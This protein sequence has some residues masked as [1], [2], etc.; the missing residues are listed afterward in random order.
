[1]ALRFLSDLAG[2]MLSYFKISTLRLKNDSN[3]LRVRNAGDSSD[4]PLIA[5]LLSATGEDIELNQDAA[6]SG[7]DWKMTLR[8]PSSGMTEARVIT[9]PSGNPSVGQAVRVATYAGGVVGLDYV[10]LAGA[11]DQAATDTTTLAFGD[12]SPVSMFTKQANALVQIIRVIIDT[13]FNG[14]PT[15]SIGI[16]GTTSKYSATSEVDLTAAA[17]SIFEI[18]PED[19]ATGGTEAL[20]I[21]YAAGGASAG[22]ARVLVTTVVPS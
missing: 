6:G 2:T 19:V 8:R 11:A 16:A 13:P 17:G 4:L 3:V 14:T 18:V 1:M 12:S 7:A 20:I 5:S 15:M 9:L 10:T 21:T 22:S